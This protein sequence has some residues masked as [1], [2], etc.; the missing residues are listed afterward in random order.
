M[1]VRTFHLGDA[2]SVTSGYLL[3][4]RHMDGVYDILNFLTGD[5]LFTHQLPRACEAAGPYLLAKYS[6]LVPVTRECEMAAG[7]PDWSA[8]HAEWLIEAATRHG[9]HFDLEPM[10]PGAWLQIDPVKELAAMVGEEKV[11]VVK[12]GEVRP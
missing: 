1:N 5:N 8:R 4:P 7:A 2:L 11:L 6:A 3:S 9:S 12:P 10:P